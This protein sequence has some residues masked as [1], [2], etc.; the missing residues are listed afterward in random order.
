MDGFIGTTDQLNAFIKTAD[1]AIEASKAVKYDADG[2]IKTKKVI[3]S[4]GVTLSAGD[5]DALLAPSGAAAQ[6]F[7][8]PAVADAKGVRFEFVAASAAA[9][10]I[11]SEGSDIFGQIIDNS[12]AATLARTELEGS[13][14]II[15][16]NP[17]I[18]D[19]ITII[20]DGARYF[21]DGRTNDTP[22]LAK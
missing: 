11:Q 2:A 14:R 20:S 18:G 6:T 1:A 15:L 19:R 3:K 13:S 12:N 22:G 9:H 21:V 5:S 17:K 8:L 10:I 7:V 16:Q 4:S